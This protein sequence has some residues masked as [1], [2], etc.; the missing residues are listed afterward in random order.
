MRLSG[1]LSLVSRQPL[2]G[3]IGKR[4][5]SVPGSVRRQRSSVLIELRMPGIVDRL[6][7]WPTSISVSLLPRL[8]RRAWC[9]GGGLHI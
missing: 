1:K 6:D 2:V 5:C 8:I 3:V 9:R 7:P 4:R